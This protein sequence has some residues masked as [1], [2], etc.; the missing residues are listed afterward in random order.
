[1]DTLRLHPETI[2]EV[3]QRLDIVEIVSDFVVL[4]KRGKDYLGLCPFHDE[5]TPSFSVS[6]TKQ[7]YYCFGCSAGGN[8][9]K[10][11]ME[12]GKQS[13]SDVVFDLA[14]RYQ[15]PLKTLNPEQKQELQRQISEK[16][17][18]YEIMAVTGSFYHHALHQSQGEKALNYLKK[19]RQLTEATIEAFQL[20]Y[21]PPGWET[22]Y[23]YL[24]E[25][26]RYP[27]TLVESAG[28]IKKRQN[29]ASGYYDQFR[30]RL[31]IPICDSQGRIIA[32]GS[33]TLTGEEPKY[34]NSPETPLFDKG[35]TLFALDKA[36]SSI[37]KKDQAVVVEGYFDAIAL[38]GVGIENVVAS[39]G[40]A[41]SQNQLKQLLRYSESKQVVFNFDADK[42]GVQAT[43]RAIEE[44][45]P[46]VY[47]GQVQLKI[48]NIPDG[49]DADEFLKSSSTA[50]ETYKS[51]LETAPLWLDWQIKQLL[52]NKDLKLG[53]Q[54]QKVAKGMVSLLQKLEDRN[55]RAHYTRHCAEILAQGDSRSIPMQI[56]SIGR[57]LKKPLS[58]KNN[59]QTLTPN[60]DKQL[61]EEAE[62]LILLIYLHCPEY[63]QEIHENLET[64]DLF[65]SLSDH[66]FLWQQLSNLSQDI[67][68]ENTLL[69]RL[70]NQLFLFPD[71]LKNLNHF[72]H[73]NE[74][75]T[76]DIYRTSM[77]LQNAIAT[78]ER[79]SRQYYCDYCLQK[80][81]NLAKDD[82]PQAMYYY[83]EYLQ[84]RTYIKELDQLRL[85]EP[86][87]IN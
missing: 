72:F 28:L 1:M 36:R 23:R 24:V 10:F 41:F 76:E 64:K 13:F 11:L 77:R 78:I 22:L 2:E 59:T 27:L 68:N 37:I 3:K 84:T 35:K 71:K 25:Q 53:D 14:R 79:E 82:T 69:S 81:H 18:L 75:E 20:G 65:F 29:G 50:I 73:L 58:K 30:D 60:S 51:L 42:A 40:T 56:E 44:I 66:R 7:M 86:E 12:L 70:Q 57:Q 34:L 47:S 49:K 45:A 8:G 43:Q 62:K 32:F 31:M 85:T 15:I 33:R 4:K 87:N 83:E 52:I 54:F 17:H 38:H 46:L 67:N 5:K 6:P 16:E 55:Q 19:E 26:K 61:L 63:R 48:L 74:I 39:L 21:S 80:S 9:I